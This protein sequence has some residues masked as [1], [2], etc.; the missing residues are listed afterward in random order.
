MSRY[1]NANSGLLDT[2]LELLVLTK[3]KKLEIGGRLI[4]AEVAKRDPEGFINVIKRL[5]SC[6]WSEYE[7][8]NDYT[9]VK[10]LDLPDFAR[11]W[12]REQT[13]A[14]KLNEHETKIHTE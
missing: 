7:F 8:S 9:E 6:G 3:L 14:L 13:K 12:Y 4:I 10:R 5:I 1:V 2:D 11:D